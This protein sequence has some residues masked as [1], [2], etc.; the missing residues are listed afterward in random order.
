MKLN[1]ILD[2]NRKDKMFSCIYLWTNLINGKHY[3]GQTQ[4]FYNRMTNYKNGRATPYLKAAIEKYGL[5]NFS[6]D[7]IEYCEIEE[8]DEK[9]Q[10]WIDYY[11]SYNRE[12]GYNICRYA[13]NTRGFKHSEETKEK[14]RQIKLENPVRLCGDK[15]PMYGKEKS[16]EAKRKISNYLKE[17]WANDTEYRKNQSERMAGDR[18]YF[19]GKHLCGE[20]NPMYGKHHSEETRRKISEANKGHCS[21]KICMPV[22]CIETEEIFQSMTEA[23][24]KLNTYA[25]AIKIAVDNPNRTCKGFHF[26]KI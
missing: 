5:E 21:E 11:E 1:E 12:K 13:S 20:E 24:K 18:N 22:K 25:S 10:Y 2:G 4:H 15:N 9:E 6:I 3:V 16:E 26:Q 14:L 7:V 8:L 19:Y 17:K 23:A